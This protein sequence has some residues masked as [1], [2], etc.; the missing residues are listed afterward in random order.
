MSKA[1]ELAEM[2]EGVRAPYCGAAAAELR[3]LAAV[4]A[5]RDA[6]KAENERLTSCLKKANDQAEDFERRWYLADME[7]D[8]IRAKE[9]VAWRWSVKKLNGVEW[10][11]TLHQTKPESEPLYT[12]EKP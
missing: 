4:E 2:I 6:L 7:L 1:L 12:L 11:Y 9:P 10:R 5:E 8:R 3:R